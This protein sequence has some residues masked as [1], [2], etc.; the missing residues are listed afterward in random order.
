MADCTVTDRNALT[1]GI[2]AGGN[3][4]ASDKFRRELGEVMDDS[5]FTKECRNLGSVCA[6]YGFRRD[7][8]A[9][10]E[11]LL[12]FDS[13]KGAKSSPRYFVTKWVGLRLNAVKRGFILDS[14]VTPALLREITSTHCPVSHAEFVFKGQ[15]PA[16]PS[17]D[18]V[19]NEGTYAVANLAALT[20]RVNRAKGG[21]SFGEVVAI[22]ER[23][24]TVEGLTASEWARLATL[25]YGG[26]HAVTGENLIFPLAVVPPRH[27]F[28]P[29]CQLVQLL[30][31]RWCTDAALAASR[32]ELLTRF[33]SCART[34]RGGQ[35][36][37]R[38]VGLVAEM[39]SREEF[40]ADVWLSQHVFEVFS[41][42]YRD[43]HEN[44]D[45]VLETAHQRLHVELDEQEIIES[46]ALEP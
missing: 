5:A 33:R 20:Q 17:V 31:L 9:P 8:R 6:Q 32:G 7:A 40:P 16:N 37:D 27:L 23:D 21:K 22:A 11:L 19:L 35:C 1:R 15:S 3:A 44:I 41:D 30:L 45:V 18:R 39:V 34:H 28:T 14:S 26:W 25:M 46:W 4:R 10:A 24:E 29:T 42:W 36:F 12:A 43:S 38:L 13:Y 2:H